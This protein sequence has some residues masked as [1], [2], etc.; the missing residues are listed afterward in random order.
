LIELTL[1]NHSSPPYVDFYDVSMVDGAN[2]PVE[3]QPI[4]GTF[5][6]SGNPYTCGSPGC[7]ARTCPNSFALN[8]CSWTFNAGIYAS[9]L[10]QTH[11][12]YCNSNS[13]CKHGNCNF[14]TNV[15][16]C[17]TDSDCVSGQQCGSTFIPGSVL[18]VFI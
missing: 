14:Q 18:V 2:I 12:T 9:A 10:L 8:R 11:P 15:C 6:P 17:N 3:I 7:T 4:A 1:I 5:T 16:P 13:Q